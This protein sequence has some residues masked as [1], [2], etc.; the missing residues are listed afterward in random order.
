MGYRVR[1]EH[2]ELRFR[3]FAELK[4]ACR[5]HMVEPDDELLEDGA[6]TWRKASSLP[7]LWEVPRDTRPP[8]QR[9]G[10]WYVFAALMVGAAAYFV[11]NGWDYLSI[12]IAAV[13]FVFFLVWTTLSG[14]RRRR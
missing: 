7:R 4:E 13:V 5:Q 11:I 12:A 14:T 3:S 6:T 2:G 8:W 10:K 1:N 9:E